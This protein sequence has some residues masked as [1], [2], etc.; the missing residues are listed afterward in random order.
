[1]TDFEFK[2]NK[3]KVIVKPNS[4]ETKILD[5]D[6]LNQAYIISLKSAPE[7]NKANI[8]LL[9]FIS[10]LTG[11]KARIARGLK[12]KEKIITLT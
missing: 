12:S 1:M 9:K 2:K 4:R 5:F 3:F 7:N 11:K 8:E 10:R 6:S